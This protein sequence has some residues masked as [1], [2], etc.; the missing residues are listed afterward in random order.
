MREE[1]KRILVADDDD[2][3]RM[4]L[5]SLLRRRGF[6]VDGVR[7][8]V[9]VLARLQTC[10]YA[11]LVLDLALP[12]MSG[13]EVME[14]LKKAPA[15][16]RPIII[17]LTPADEPRGLDSGLVVG[18]IS[19][20]FEVGMLIDAV[21]ACANALPAQSQLRDCPPADSTRIAHEP[22]N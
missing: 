7:T 12:V 22:A 20:P 15:E 19:K 11:V 13:W 10:N 5:F 9:E 14:E 17:V 18:S 3:I 2:A 16:N 8:G 21:S 1:E 6:K 4:L